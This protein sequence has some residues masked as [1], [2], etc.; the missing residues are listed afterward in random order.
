MAG[1]GF[2]VESFKSSVRNDGILRNHSFIVAFSPPNKVA[3]SIK[4][5]DPLSIARA[6]SIRCDSVNIPGID[7]QS[8]QSIYRYGY[9]PA[10]KHV[11][12]VAFKDVTLSF[13]SDAQAHQYKVFNQWMNLIYNMDMSKGIDFVS[14]YTGGEPYQ[15]EYRDQYAVDMYIYV[16]NEMTQQVLKI[17]MLEAYPISLMDTQMAWGLQNDV[18]RMY[19]TMAYKSFFIQT[20]DISD[21]SQGQSDIPIDVQQQFSQN[22]PPPLVKTVIA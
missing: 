12:G 7:L 10:E 3:D 18:V 15:V 11:Y 16:Y 4:D 5:T 19:V 14:S 17:V 6:M 9:G 1:L 22:T 20:V 21:G 8:I 2:S 13:L